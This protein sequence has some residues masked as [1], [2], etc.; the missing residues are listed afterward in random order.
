MSENPEITGSDAIMF[1]FLGNEEFKLV[2]T[3][4]TW[5]V[6]SVD[7]VTQPTGVVGETQNQKPINVE[8]SG[9]V[10]ASKSEVFKLMTIPLKDEIERN[11][12]KQ[13]SIVQDYEMSDR[14]VQFVAS[15][16][17]MKWEVQ[18]PGQNDT[19]KLPFTYFCNIKDVDLP[20]F[21]T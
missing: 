18:T 9:T 4:H 1:F 5:K 11:P 14:T 21:G 12:R 20:D 7:I 16:C 17:R 19:V 13:L 8:G 15:R 3:D 10:V 2:V 6:N